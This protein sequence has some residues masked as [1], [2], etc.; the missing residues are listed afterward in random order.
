MPSLDVQKSSSINLPRLRFLYII[1]EMT[2]VYVLRS[3]CAFLNNFMDFLHFS[4][5]K[6]IRISIFSIDEKGSRHRAKVD[7]F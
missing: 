4:L 3:K 5:D 6:L 7:R 2:I 1:H